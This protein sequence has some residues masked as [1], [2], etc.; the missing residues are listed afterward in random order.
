MDYTAEERALR[1]SE[2][3]ERDAELIA[4]QKRIGVLRPKHTDHTTAALV[5]EDEAGKG[6]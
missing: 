1:Q 4:E 6:K 5:A 3:A 2:Q